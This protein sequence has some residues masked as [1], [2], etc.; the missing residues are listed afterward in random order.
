MKADPSGIRDSDVG[1]VE[2][3][4]PLPGRSFP[5]TIA[6]GM[7]R[8]FSPHRMAQRRDIPRKVPS[9]PRRDLVVRML[10]IGG[11]ENQACFT[12]PP[13]SISE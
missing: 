5:W 3:V 9:S 8:A 11:A 2:H 1:P 7:K 10:S 4:A 6:C 13:G 12:Y